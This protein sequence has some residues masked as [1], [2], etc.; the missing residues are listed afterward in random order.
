MEFPTPPPAPS[1]EQVEAYYEATSNWGRWGDDDQRGALNSLTDEHRAAGA[2][3]VRRGRSVSLAHDLPVTP[4]PE[5]PS[6]AHHHMLASGDARDSNGIPGYEASRDYVGT[7][8]HGMG[9]TH[10]DALCHMFIRGQMYN[11]RPAEQVKSTGSEANTIMALAE[12]LSGRGV[13]LDVPRAFGLPHLPGN[14][15]LGVAHLEAAEAALGVAVGEGDILVVGT[16]R[17]ARKAETGRLDPF[18]DGLAGLHA[19]CLPWLHDRGIA[20]L[21]SDGI[22][23]PTPGLGIPDWPFPIHQVGIVGMGLHLIDNLALGPLGD[24]CAEEGRWEFFFTLAPLRV[25]G[26]TG[27]PVNPVAVL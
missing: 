8:V 24:V 12:G 14:T 5:T 6:P 1:A 22:S 11:G 25:V 9:V 4:S 18:R 20:V 15:A 2:A 3:L 7:D 27:C 16:G 13:F 21:G 10:V 23:D 26:G 19:E 17:D